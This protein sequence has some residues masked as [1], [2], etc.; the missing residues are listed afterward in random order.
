VTRSLE[1]STARV[2]D[3]LVRDALLH[4]EATS[5]RADKGYV[6]AEGEAAFTDEAKVWGVMRKAPKGGALQ[7][8]NGKINRI[9]AMVRARVEHPFRIRRRQF[10]TVKTRYRGLARNRARIGTLFALANLF[11]VRRRLPACARVR[12]K[13]ARPPTRRALNRKINRQ[14]PAPPSP[15]PS[16]R[17]L[18]AAQRPDRTLRGSRSR[19]MRLPP[20]RGGGMGWGARRRPV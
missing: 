2:H 7:P 11:L 4:G 14:R 20:P 8:E 9:I 5:V 19:G 15:K 12:P 16:R 3:S 17:H 6:S 1:T 10:G 18:G 13:S